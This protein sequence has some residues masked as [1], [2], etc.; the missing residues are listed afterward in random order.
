MNLLDR[1][2]QHGDFRLVGGCVRDGILGT[3]P[4][5]FDIVT[6]LPPRDLEGLGLSLERIGAA[7]PTYQTR[8][9]T[10]L[11]I[12]IAVARTEQKS[13]TGYK[14]FTTE[15]TL[16]IQGDLERRDFT[17]NACAWSMATGLTMSDQAR[18]D[19]DSRTLRHITP[20]FAEDPLRVMRA[21]R[22]AAKLGWDVAPE[23]MA[24]MPSLKGELPGLAMERVKAEMVTSL[25][26]KAPSRFFEV[27]G[28]VGGLDHWF[29]EVAGLR[30]VNH[31]HPD[32]ALNHHP[33]GD[34]FVHTLL[35]LNWARANGAGLDAIYA[36]L[37]H[38]FGKAL[39]PATDYP[40]MY[41]HDILAEAPI[42]GFSDRFGLGKQT[43]RGMHSI[44]TNIT[45]S[46]MPW[47]CARRRWST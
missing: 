16:D 1:L 41:G 15:L 5:D 29:P 38:D 9:P 2:N 3:E 45:G 32:P 37:G 14:G 4:K 13:G 17:V 24:M 8:T 27:L 18:R 42:D 21:A 39:I 19:F 34:A 10:G 28:E 20:A 25:Q 40:H 35:V 6:T 26:S 23:T 11:K 30:G 12:E 44:A 33:E 43:R 46:M 22:F 36:A 7:F 31:C 47:C